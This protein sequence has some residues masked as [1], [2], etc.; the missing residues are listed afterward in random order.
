[1]T[2]SKPSSTYP[3]GLIL[4]IAGILTSLVPAGAPTQ[5]QPPPPGVSQAD[6]ATPSAATSLATSLAG[7][8]K[9]GERRTGEYGKLPLSFESNQGQTDKTV[10][11]LARGK[12]YSLFLAPTEA[13]FV[14]T[15][16]SGAKPQSPEDR[17]KNDGGAKQ[18]KDDDKVSSAAA[19]LRMQLICANAAAAANGR[20]ELA[21]KVNYFIGNDPAKWRTNVSTFGQVRY[22]EVYPGI[23]LVY[24]GNGRQLE[25]DFVVAPG[26]GPRAIALE[27]A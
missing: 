20:Q 14:L 17:L 19:V 18:R 4:A 24:Y 12:G 8:S 7:A 27:F 25:Y 16:Q 5:K 2:F 21:G 22:K 26:R 3:S 6:P 9:T 11:F 10:N 15:H 13:T 23:D 1:M